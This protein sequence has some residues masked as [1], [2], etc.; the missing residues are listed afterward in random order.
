M[1][2]KIKHRLTSSSLAFLL[3][4]RAQHSIT[5]TPS[6]SCV[7]GTAL[8]SSETEL[9]Q[10]HFSPLRNLQSSFQLHLSFIYTCLR[11]LQRTNSVF[12]KHGIWAS[13]DDCAGTQKE[14]GKGGG[15]SQRAGFA[16]NSKKGQKARGRERSSQ[17]F[18]D[19]ERVLWFL[20]RL[21]SRGYPCTCWVNHA[22]GFIVHHLNF[23]R[24]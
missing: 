5:D 4:L 18:L 1:A 22:Q 14:V 12:P 17:Q 10:S 20:F 23:R 15:C 6:T 24:D 13:R 21:W 11:D 8:G 7:P 19:K 3:L 16:S 9:N 2:P